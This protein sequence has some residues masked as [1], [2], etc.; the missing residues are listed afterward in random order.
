M[1]S[2]VMVFK[3]YEIAA[4]SMWYIVTQ[5]FTNIYELTIL[6][7]TATHLFTYWYKFVKYPDPSYT[8]W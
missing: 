8:L 7:D 5:S 6:R 2:S 1:V 3:D 4:V